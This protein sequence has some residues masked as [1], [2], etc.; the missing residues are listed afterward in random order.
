G[1]EVIERLRLVKPVHLQDPVDDFT[2]TAERESSVTSHDRDEIE[3]K[4]RCERLVGLDF[5]FERSLSQRKRRKIQEWKFYRALDL[6]GVVAGE[7]HRGRVCV[8]AH[9]F[10]AVVS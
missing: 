1:G 5:R 8:D 4:L 6:V 3:I 2:V 7:K 10:S 9:D